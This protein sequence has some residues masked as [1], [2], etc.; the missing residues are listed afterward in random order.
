MIDASACIIDLYRCHAAA[1]TKARGTVLQAHAWL[2]RF[3]DMLRHGTA[4]LDIGCGSGALPF[5]Q[6]SSCYRCRRFVGND[7]VI[8][9]QSA[10][11]DI[12]SGGYALA[13][14]DR[15]YGGLIAWDSFFHL[16]PLDQRMMFPIFRDHA[17]PAAPLLFTSGPAFGG[18]IGALEGE[19]LYH[20]SFDPEE[21]RIMLDRNGFDIV[22]HVAE[23]P[24]CSGHTVWLARRR[25][26]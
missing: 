18:A 26:S 1:W 4:V 13:D 24:D 25:Q 20:A 16:A 3:A 21:Y 23:D 15:R 19:S 12:P 5:Q 6:R 10:R 14:I 17:E 7:R 2:G 9:G 22:S 11:R 8:P